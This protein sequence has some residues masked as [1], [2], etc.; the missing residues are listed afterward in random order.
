MNLKNPQEQVL[1][2]IA[3]DLYNKK[4]FIRGDEGTNITFKCSTI[5]ELIDL[6]QKCAKLL[7]TENFTYR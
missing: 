6:K 2:K 7:K 4:I 5:N 3:I 1:D